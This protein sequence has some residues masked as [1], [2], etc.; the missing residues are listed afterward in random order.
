LFASF[1]LL[2]ALPLIASAASISLA[3]DPNNPPPLE[4]QVFLRKS[5]Q[6]Y[7]YG[8]PAWHGTA[9]QCTLDNL[10]DGQTY[11]VVARAY[12]GT[13]ESADSNEVKF[14]TP[15]A[16]ASDPPAPA[17]Q[18]P[19][20]DAG[21]DQAVSAGSMV[22]LDGS[23]SQDPDGSIS[24]Y[25]WTQIGG[26]TVAL[27]NADTA[28][29]S[30]YAPDVSSSETLT[31]QI[32]VIDPYGLSAVATC[33]VTV[34][35]VTQPGSSDPG[36]GNA[37]G[38]SGQ[39]GALMIVDNAD[40]AFSKVGTW[41]VSDKANDYYGNDYAY[42]YA[43][44]GSYKA[45]FTFQIPTS[46]NYEIAA[47][48]TAHKSRALD[49]PYTLINNGAVLDT[50]RVDQRTEGGQF[51][52]L[53]GGASLGD[54]TYT[55]SAGVLEVVLSN[56]ASGKVAADAVR[57]MDAGAT[58]SSSVVPDNSGDSLIVDSVITDNA[59]AAFSK[60]GTWRVSDKANDYYGSDYA[61][62]YAGNGS[63]KATFT[64]EVPADGNYEIAAQWTAHTSRAPDAPYTLINNGVVLDTIRVD[65]RT[66]G[67][68]FN[69]LSGGASL[70]DGTYALSAGVL[71]VVL[72]N[73]A[74]GKV[75]ADAVRVMD[76]GTTVDIPGAQ[77]NSVDNLSIIDSVITDN[78]DAAF[79][80][81]GTWKASNKADGFYGDDYV[82]SYAGDGSSKATF[83]FEIP[84]DGNYEIA[85]QW[86]AHDTRAPDAPFTLV[87]NGVVLDTIRVNQQ[88]DGGQFNPLTGSASQGDGTYALSAGVLE[89]VLSNNASGKVA[90]DA[91]RIGP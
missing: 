67:G 71:E 52:T 10:D 35:P 11:Y 28:S 17:N 53:S 58:D 16:T 24:T 42:A 79:S 90:A 26:Q 25:Q 80:K 68:Q 2:L 21:V 63:S 78:A 56:D 15:S 86:P 83:T 73:D 46:G 59:D 74:S 30:F 51:N 69:T 84:A 91:V 55:L 37:S 5:G 88:I 6:A 47:Q 65:Q 44:S 3:W 13:D 38:S 76:M 87:N 77:D 64:F 66:K 20:A 60:V 7:S 61:Y 36:S 22:T 72:S 57:V 75:A 85:A 33:Q 82:F 70:G 41:R 4:Y 43:G 32:E 1:F 9:T 34:V 31:F 54:G 39:T 23:A 48:W 29:A 40:A 89:V 12:S 18:E 14:T 49:A 62:A 45:T 19:V 8:S 27:E 50:I 81:V